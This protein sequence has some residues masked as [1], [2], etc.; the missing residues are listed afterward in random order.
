[1]ETTRTEACGSDL[2]GS[3]TAL[4]QRVRSED[5]VHGVWEVADLQWWWRR[6]R[7]TDAWD[8]PIWVDDAGPVAAVVATDWEHAVAIDAF[9]L[10]SRGDLLPEVW[11]AA[12]AV[13]E[14]HHDATFEVMVDDRDGD[15]VARL[16]A[17]GF[18]PLPETG[19]SAWVDAG[20]LRRLDAELP[21]GYRIT[22]RATLRESMPH[23]FSAT[24]GANVE[25]RLQETSLYRDE[26]DLVVVTDTDDVAAYALFWIDPAT[27]VGFVEPVGTVEGHRRRGLARALLG[28]GLVALVDTGATRLKVN[29]NDANAAAKR[30][31]LRVGFEPTMWTS[32]WVR[33]PARATSYR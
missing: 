5:A 30:L 17:A 23:H 28:A 14:N 13:L 11:E 21:A 31:Y 22:S 7:P 19:V 33:R 1:M 18:H 27:G 2:L 29:Y 10:P 32:L 9:V 12:M 3:T 4:L 20:D 25:A 16:E 8:M 24:N 6:A 15:S 26:L